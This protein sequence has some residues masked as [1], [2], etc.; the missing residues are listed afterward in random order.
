L[1]HGTARDITEF[2]PKQANA[3][4]LTDNPRFAEGFTDAS[5][6]Y[7]VK[8]LANRLS[9]EELQKLAKEADKRAK[10]SGDLP[11]EEMARV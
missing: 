9:S 7:M 1:Y 6:A 8:E 4:F 2:K 10:K 3:I 11:E 5:E